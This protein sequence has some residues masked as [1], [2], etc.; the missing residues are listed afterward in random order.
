MRM[1]IFMRQAGCACCVGGAVAVMAGAAGAQEIDR[2]T[3]G[4]Y[5]TPGL[6]DMPTAQSMPDGDMS[7]TVN[8][9][10]EVLR[11]TLTFQITPRLS[12]TFRYSWLNGFAPS[13]GE[14]DLY[15]RS[16]D[17]RYRFLDEGTYMPAMAVGLQDF[18]GT[19]VFAGEYV[20]ATKTIT[21]KLTVTGGIGW[22][23][24]GSSGGFDNPLGVIADGFKTRPRFNATGEVALNTFFR[25]DAALF[26][27]VEYRPTPRLGFKLEYS[28]D[29]Y[30][31]ETARLG[32]D[33]KSPFNLSATYR[34]ANGADLTAAYLH[35]S[36]VGVMLNYTLNPRRPAVPTGT[37]P[38]GPAV[39]PRGQSL[40][41][42]G[43]DLDRTA[44][45]A[46][47]AEGQDLIAL[48]V[49]GNRARLKL[50]NT[51]FNAEPEALGRA[52]RAMTGLLSPDVETISIVSVSEGGMA[53]SEVS[54]QRR[55][56]E[57]LEMALDGSWQSFARAKITDAPGRDGAG[58]LADAYPA[59]D[60]S[61]KAYL[62]PTYFDPD[63]PFRYDA[64]IEL[65]AAF[66]PAPGWVLSGQIRQPLAGNRNDVTRT[67]ESVL[68]HVRSDGGLYDKAADLEITYL[69]GEYFFRPGRNLYGRVTA[70]YLERMYGGVSTELLWK[71]VTGHLALGAE[72]NYAVQRDFDV[73]FGF[74]DYDIVTG[75][76]SLY[77]DMGKGYRAQIDAGRYL[78]GDWGATV[79]LD[80]EFENGFT[81]GAFFTLTD[82]SFDDFGEGSFDKGIRVTIPI[83]W[84]S[85]DPGRGTFS[86]TIRPVLRDGGARLE[87]RNRLYDV[88]RGSHA[89]ELQEDWGRFW[90]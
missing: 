17:L 53:L 71:P 55:D 58:L 43:S 30:T 7:L 6:I 29:A 88:T 22:G 14:E 84:L 12:G 65:N 24:L 72:L 26:G 63:S 32:F 44:R 52:A 70:G 20:V 16:F 75:H 5:G 21:P 68:P 33:R 23:R 36:A 73:L 90:R 2:P 85:G 42:V 80:R 51:R 81:V 31:Q 35:G 18:G 62:S 13:S 89:N 87:V 56:L 46:L 19:G 8:H 28:S 47:A 38:A 34:F 41:L 49:A 10:G 67:S 48:T 64:G 9:Y 79:S 45:A 40:A 11:N 66:R 83:T 61:P 82:V 50:R 4:F 76:A 77:Y 27:G 15:D 86:Q 39:V 78:A 37:E 1:P 59:F 25:G 57:E 69:T 3:L 54:F 60:F 74:Q